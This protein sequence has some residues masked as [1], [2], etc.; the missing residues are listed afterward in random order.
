MLTKVQVKT[1]PKVFV[2][3]DNASDEMKENFAGNMASNVIRNQSGNFAC[4]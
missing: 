2:Q 4:N 3:P 1:Q